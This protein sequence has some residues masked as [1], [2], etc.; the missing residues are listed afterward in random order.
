MKFWL[1]QPSS[2]DLIG[3][4]TLDEVRAQM[5]AGTISWDVQ[6]L[7]ATGQSL[8]SLKHSTDWVALSSVL[9]RQGDPGSPT[10]GNSPDSSNRLVP[11]AGG[12]ASSAVVTRYRDAY[13]VGAALVG[14]GNA[15]KAAGAV[16][17]GIIV[18]SSLSKGDG[19]FAAAG[20]FLGATAGLLFRVCGVMVA[21]QGQVLRATLDT[22]VASSHF[23]TDTERAD[24]M[25]LPHTVVDRS[26]T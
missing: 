10:S 17:G 12:R 21:A 20:V 16:L 4:L 18:V 25:G 9:P 26:R 11:S 6:A 5:Q 15:I 24:A 7:E 22:A 14:L 2:L 13:R 19:P 3:P 8:G 23:L 1:K